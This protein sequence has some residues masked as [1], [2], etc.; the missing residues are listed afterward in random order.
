MS[1]R[2]ASSLTPVGCRAATASNARSTVAADPMGL[3]LAG[4]G[5]YILRIAQ[6]N[7]VS[8]SVPMAWQQGSGAM[9]RSSADSSADPS[10]GS[11]AGPVPD[12]KLTRQQRRAFISAFGGWSLDGYNAG[13]F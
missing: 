3:T 12:H 6:W 5:G 13:L 11:V 8:H 10:A 2:R 1:R 9:A 4:D 7:D